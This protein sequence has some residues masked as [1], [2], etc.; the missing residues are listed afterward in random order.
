MSRISLKAGVVFL[1]VLTVCGSAVAAARVSAP[2]LPPDLK[3]TPPDSSLSKDIAGFSGTW[4]GSW[5]A[6]LDSTLVVEKVDSSSASIVYSWGV[7]SRWGVSNPGF[8]RVKA[9]IGSDG[10]LRATL[11]NGAQVIYRLSSDQKTLTGQYIRGGQT[12]QGAFRRPEGQ[13]Q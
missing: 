7:A 12:T 8:T 11:G 13:N 9:T 1:A 10:L 5:G 2:P 4:V 3:V 6:T